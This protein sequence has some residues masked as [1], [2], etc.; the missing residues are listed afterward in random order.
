MRTTSKLSGLNATAVALALLVSAGATAAQ[1]ELRVCADPDNLPYSNQEREGFENKLVDLIAK[2]L[3]AKVKY[4]W[5]RSRR[6]LV[7]RTLTAKACDV[8][9]GIP[10]GLEK[11]LTTKPYYRSTYVFVYRKSDN[12]HLRSFDDP[13]LR[14]LKIGLHAIGSEGS[15]PP[16]AYALARRGIASNVVGFGMWDVDSMKNPQGRI[17]DAV[18][19]GDIDVAIVWGTFGGYFAKHQKTA[20]AVVPVSPAIEPPGIPFVFDISMGVR[21]GDT[22]L[23]TELERVLDRRRKDIQ[24]I[25]E[26]YGI[27][28]VRT[29]TALAAGTREPRN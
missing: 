19:N 4:T 15:N 14:K 26:A 6:A 11:T 5:A 10:A 25:L 2:D 22:A 23:K 29:D 21:P 16:P 28:I 12:L 3:H 9:P 8:L 27:P 13:A 17:I 24:K 18:A 7:R 20:L 1:R